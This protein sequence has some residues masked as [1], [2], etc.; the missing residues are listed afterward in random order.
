MSDLID[1]VLATTI[2]GDCTCG[3]CA[4]APQQLNQPS[5]H[6]VDVFFFRVAANPTNPPEAEELRRLTGTH[7]GE[8]GECD[9]FDGT[10]HSY[11][12][13]GGWIGDQGIALMFMGASALAG[14]TDV[15]EPRKL[16]PG[17]PE[18]LY[19]AMAGQGMVAI[20]TKK[21]REEAKKELAKVL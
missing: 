9:P 17:L 18:G 11:I 12:E 21:G 3:R 20:N 16:L 14:I 1:Y 5:G 13:L 4:D 19:Q 7:R 8:F 2:R 15:L 10:E 6:T